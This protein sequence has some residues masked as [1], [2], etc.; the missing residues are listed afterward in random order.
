MDHSTPSLN[1]TWENFLSILTI[2]NCLLLF[3]RKIGFQLYVLLWVLSFLKTQSQ[4]SGQ[5]QCAHTPQT[6]VWALFSLT[7]L[8]KCPSM[9]FLRIFN[10][11][12]HDVQ[13]RVMQT[14]HVHSLKSFH[15][16]TG[17]FRQ[18]QGRTGGVT[19]FLTPLKSNLD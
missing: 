14:S 16:W 18:H 17:S 10:L 15:R 3:Y 19:Q 2:R 8:Q 4:I 7:F 6:Q 9:S 12:Y 5:V 1:D 11:S 13:F